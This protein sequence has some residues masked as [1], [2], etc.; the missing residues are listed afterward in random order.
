MAPRHRQ[1]NSNVF[2]PVSGGLGDVVRCYLR[3]THEWGYIPDIK[4][5]FPYV[6]IKILSSC[7]NPAVEEFFKYNPH[8]DSFK[9]F[10]WIVDGWQLFNKYKGSHISLQDIIKRYKK[11]RVKL[12]WT[13]PFY[14]TCQEDI[15]E[16]NEITQDTNGIIIMHPFTIRKAL[17]IEDFCHM[18]DRL[19]DEFG[20]TVIF[21]GGTHNRFHNVNLQ[22]KWTQGIDVVEELNYERP[23]LY[24]LLNKSNIRVAY[25]LVEL[26]DG[27]I[28]HCSCFNIAAWIHQK[29][30]VVF[31]PPCQRLILTTN[32]DYA[33][34]LIDNLPWCKNYYSDEW[35]SSR[36][37][38]NEAVEFFRR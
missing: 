7:H 18:A 19:I 33:W 23:G 4:R 21:L 5:I 3:D 28:G 32:R 16:V 2:I 24:N 30:S 36:H 25:K 26:C 31:S 13:Q 11:S 15:E 12:K 6:T 27:F 22:G 20:Y 29:K 8:I 38:A 1:L 14:Y 17:P 37:V 34:P 10:G 9:E 35:T